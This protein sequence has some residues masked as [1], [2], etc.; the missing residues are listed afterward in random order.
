M[1]TALQHQSHSASNVIAYYNFQTYGQ[2]PS[3]L[4]TT[5]MV[6]E[7]QGN[8]IF[9]NTEEGKG[10]KHVLFMLSKYTESMSHYL[11]ET[12]FTV[13]LFSKPLEEFK[14]ENTNQSNI[15]PAFNMNVNP[16]YND[17]SG[18]LRACQEMKT[19]NDKLKLENDDLRK[20]VE[21][22][23]KIVRDKERLLKNEK[24]Q[25]EHFEQQSRA[26]RGKIKDL[27]LS[28]Q[29][30]EV[31]YKNKEKEKDQLD[32]ELKSMSRKFENERERAENLATAKTQ[33]EA[34]LYQSKTLLTESNR[35]LKHKDAEI[36]SYVEKL[37]KAEELIQ[38]AASIPTSIPN[39][40]SEYAQLLQD[41][42]T[43]NQLIALCNLSGIKQ[44][45]MAAL[46]SMD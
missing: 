2:P 1:L 12:D 36:K 13:L 19:C 17:T 41:P 28:L 10:F 6:N 8:L 34:E 18:L 9:G 25:S 5:I 42:E 15:N 46:A 39:I 14:A 35:H 30:C 20:Q 38:Q 40:K 31:R 45:P 16:E 21:A 37:K 22:Y 7:T 27:E 3:T 33:K 26:M 4:Q 24:S 29:E 44:D 11:D 43:F 23:E 32:I